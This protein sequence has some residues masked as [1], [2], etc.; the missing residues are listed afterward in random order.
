MA[1]ELQD[2]S[3]TLGH[4][5]LQGWTLSDRICSKP[6]CPG[7][8][9]M[10]K[11]S[12]QFCARCDEPPVDG[13]SSRPQ[14][15]ASGS[16][17]PTLAHKRASTSA[18]VSPAPSLPALGDFEDLR[19]GASTPP[20]PHSTAPG[21]T[22]DEEEPELVQFSATEI[23]LRR[24]QSDRAS[25]AI[26]QL[27]LK[28]WIMLGDACPDTSCY[29]VPLMARPKRAAQKEG[30]TPARDPRSFCV[31]CEK[32]YL[33]ASDMA[34]YEAF[35]A[36]SSEATKSA[37]TAT[38]KDDQT[39]KK[40]RGFAKPAETRP[41]AIRPIEDRA[42]KTQRVDVQPQ[43]ARDTLSQASGE[44]SLLAACEAIRAKIVQQAA[45]L[46]TYDDADRLKS[47]AETIFTLARALEQ[48]HKCV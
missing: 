48:V 39:S 42:R 22:H 2:V 24:A 10:T 35:Q 29:G 8:P 33:Q 41:L 44:P 20:T 1:S 25:E 30:E 43:M 6:G 19:S 23:A 31:V 37:A 4:Y 27:L 13:H 32:N 45:L 3:S 36:G 18:S 12:Q 5:M 47:S 9:L 7:V 40:K 46:A 15:I 14:P 26:G 21:Q 11:A 38:S 34:A 16:V 17:V 28:G